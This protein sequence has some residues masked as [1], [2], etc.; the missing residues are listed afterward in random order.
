MGLHML[1]STLY[2]EVIQTPRRQ[3]FDENHISKTKLAMNILIF[4]FLNQE[5]STK[6]NRVAK[7]T[8]HVHFNLIS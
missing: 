7:W 8:F 5:F 1:T 6:K 4:I 2:S 3:H